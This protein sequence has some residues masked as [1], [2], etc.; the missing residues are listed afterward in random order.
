MKKLFFTLLMSGITHLSASTDIES[1]ISPSLSHFYFKDETLL[2]KLFMPGISLESNTDI[3]WGF[4]ADFLFGPHSQGDVV[5]INAELSHQAVSSGNV[6]IWGV[7]GWS[8]FFMNSNNA[9]NSEIPQ[10][11][12]QVGRRVGTILPGIKIALDPTSFL[13]ITLQP[14][15]CY[16]VIS[17]H[18]VKNKHNFYGSFPEHQLGMGTK[19]GIA[20]QPQEDMVVSASYAFSQSFNRKSQ[21]QIT[22]LKLGYKY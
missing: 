21:K 20:L 11:Y 8:S 19:V 9:E 14:H 10:E 2:A 15:L 1:S 6:T 7:F 12:S 18:F 17:T 3:G 16:D 22:T 13:R 4:K 5:H